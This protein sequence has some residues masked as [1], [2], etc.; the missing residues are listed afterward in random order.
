M[1]RAV[2]IHNSS[3]S[4]FGTLLDLLGENQFTLELFD[5]ESYLHGLRTEQCDFAVLLGSDWSTYWPEIRKEVAREEAVVQSFL[6]RGV[7][8]LG[9]C[10]GAQV[11]SQTCGGQVYRLQSPEIGWKSVDGV[12]ENTLSGRWMQWHH[13]TFTVPSSFELL[14][15]NSVGTQGMIRRNCL[16]LQFHPEVDQDVVAKWI[17]SGGQSDLDSAGIEPGQLLAETAQMEMDAKARFCSLL[18]WFFEEAVGRD[19]T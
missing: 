6:A 7:P 3:D 12:S 13:D 17:S 9:V 10:F 19:R 14:G 8:L 1:A 2:V 15:F 18:E 16:A 5:R 4:E 11:I